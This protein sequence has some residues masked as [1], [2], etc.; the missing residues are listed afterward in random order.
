M[1]EY[2]QP[3]QD[4]EQFIVSS[5]VLRQADKLSPE[6]VDHHKQILASYGVV[7]QALNTLLAIPKEGWLEL[8][9]RLQKQ[10]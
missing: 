3:D 5:S 10:K 7:G 8:I 2:H 1:K 9:D 6:L 4:V